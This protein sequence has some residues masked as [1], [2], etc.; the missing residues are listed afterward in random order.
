MIVCALF[1]GVYLTICGK[2]ALI[3]LQVSPE[4]EVS[5][6]DR[7]VARPDIVDRNG[8]ILA[9]DLPVLS[10]FAEPRKVVDADEASEALAG[11]LGNMTRGT[12]TSG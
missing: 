9:T 4:E 3:G 10:L 5:T 2:L 11:A 7:T 8:A 1:V 6:L 12:S